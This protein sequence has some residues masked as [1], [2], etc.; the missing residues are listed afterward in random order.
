[1]EAGQALTDNLVLEAQIGSGAM[2]SVWKA[3]NLALHSSVAVKILK[4]GAGH[5]RGRQR[6]EQ[7]ARGLAKLDHPHI[8][9][10]FDL[11]MTEDGDPFIVMELLRGEDLA[12]R[13]GRL[14]ALDV[15]S[16]IE[17]VAQVAKALT[18]AS[19][20]GVVH[21]DI[22]PANLF[23]LE[24]EQL[25]VKVLDFGV[26]RFTHGTSLTQT[27]ALIGTPLFMSPEQF[28]GGAVD[29]RADLWSLAV[30]AYRCLTGV[31]P[32][33]G[34]TPIAVGMAVCNGEFAPVSR[35]RPELSPNLDGFFRRALTVDPNGRFQ[36][37]RALADELRVAAVAPPVPS[38]PAVPVAVGVPALS[39]KPPARGRWRVVGALVAV[40]LT[41][42]LA[43]GT[44]LLVTRSTNKPAPKST[45][46]HASITMSQAPLSTSAI[47]AAPPAS[48]AP[49]VQPD[50]L[51]DTAAPATLRA[52]H[53]L[54]VQKLGA[55]RKVVRVMFYQGY[56]VV[57]FRPQGRTLESYLVK[58]GQVGPDEDL[59]G[60]LMSVD[61][62]LPELT[63]DQVDPGIVERAQEDAL[64]RV[65]SP[66]TVLMTVVGYVVA[67]T[68]A[69]RVTLEGPKEASVEYDI[70]GTFKQ[71]IWL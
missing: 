14:G 15:A 6:F 12:S 37:A 52:L 67:P 28:A 45:K 34:D 17:L 55:K 18:R 64:R 9:K 35:V 59:N 32:F 5:E 36:T 2:G 63:L 30:V 54:M 11:G 27:G 61:E 66:S 40:A 21:R 56:A 3:Q 47:L 65:T 8:V 51:D 46:S 68:L 26:A 43:G 41:G 4:R 25:F 13:L 29:H 71:L 50:V 7:E 22:K 38:L 19:A 44:Y 57:V 53:G 31:M 10:V 69:I 33:A 62:T 70:K 24:D 58:D 20:E 48:P 23:L 60:Y 49:S 1:M 39:P 16:T 42:T